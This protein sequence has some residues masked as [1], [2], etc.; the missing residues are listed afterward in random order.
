[1]KSD[2]KS[3]RGN[4]NGPKYVQIY[5]QIKSD[6]YAEK[7]PEGSFLPTE[8]ELMEL[9]QVSKTT[10]RHAVSLLRESKLVDVQQGIGMKVCGVKRNPLSNSRYDYGSA[11]R[12]EFLTDGK[13]ETETI[14]LA[15]DVILADARVAKQL[16]LAQGSMVY[17]LQR[18]QM[19]NNQVYGY[20]VDYIPYEQAP[21]FEMGHGDQLYDVLQEKH[22]LNYDSAEETVTAVTAG[23][24]EA[25]V[26]DVHVGTPLLQLKRKVF[27]EN[28]VFV[29]AENVVNPELF[30]IVITL[31]TWQKPE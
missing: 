22:G 13:Q 16:S 10:V 15:N 11:V 27:G 31:G 23:L 26:L 5:N 20:I 8:D 19:V 21:G 17:R 4:E 29:Y 6:I 9:F 28:G 25:K 30:Q 24:M 1:M 14:E 12:M 3:I 2:G 18:L 7:Y